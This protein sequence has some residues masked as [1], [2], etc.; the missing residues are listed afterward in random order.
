MKKRILAD[1]LL[2]C[3]FFWAPWQL[4]AIFAIIFIL[5]FENYLEGAFVAIIADSFY[6]LPEAKFFSGGFGF[7]TLSSLL[8]LYLFSFVKS[9]VKIL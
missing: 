5:F 9:K 7:F 1:I 2:A 4:T 3:L 8:V 6:S